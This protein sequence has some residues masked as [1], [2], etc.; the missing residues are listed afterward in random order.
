MDVEDYYN[1]DPQYEWE[2]LERNKTEYAVTMRAF[3]D[4]LPLPPALILDIGGGPG[5]YSIALAQKGYAVTLVDISKSCLEYARRKAGELHVELTCIHGNALTLKFHREEFDAV[6]LMGPLYHLRTEDGRRKA[7]DEAARV[8]RKDGILCASFVT[9][10]APLR[11]ASK[12]EPEW[13]T[14]YPSHCEE[15]ITEGKTSLAPERESFVNISYFAHPKEINPFMEKS[16]LKT[17]DLISCEGII[18]FIDEEINMLTGEKWEAW[19]NINYTLGRDYCIHG[20][21]EHLLYIGKKQ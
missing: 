5:R 18:S 7:V 15:L 1:Q 20:A 16:G 10:Y 9:R 6:L 21:A 14:T 11:W 17:L 2:R 4:Y 13:V 19:V 12:Y 8:L 3:A